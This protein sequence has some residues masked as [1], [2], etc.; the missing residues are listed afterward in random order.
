MQGIL[1]EVGTGTETLTLEQGS[2]RGAMEAAAGSVNSALIAGALA[3]IH[4]QYLAPLVA[5][6]A[7]RAGRV[8]DQTG[9][10]V[11]AYIDG[12]Q[13][14]ADTA[15]RHASTPAPSVEPKPQM[16]PVE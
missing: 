11:Q 6:A 15:N 5:S 13:S 10:A 9:L 1:S 14:M 16:E 7:Q 3:E 8:K 12:D 2:L 4:D